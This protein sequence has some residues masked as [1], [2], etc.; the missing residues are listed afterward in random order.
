M[1]HH[2][3]VTGA[4]STGQRVASVGE[5][6]AEKVPF[7]LIKIRFF[8]HEAHGNVL[9]VRVLKSFINLRSI[10]LVKITSLTVAPLVSGRT[11][12][13]V[14]FGE[15]LPGNL[16]SRLGFI[17]FGQNNGSFLGKSNKVT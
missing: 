4:G 5:E 14:D 11:Q 17:E 7:A 6:R 1:E 12:V 13:V 3:C 8:V 9:H 2:L 10:I 15:S 16:I